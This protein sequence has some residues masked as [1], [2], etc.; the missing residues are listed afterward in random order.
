MAADDAQAIG[1]RYRQQD[2]RLRYRAGRM[3]ARRLISMRA[4]TCSPISC[5][6]GTRF[7]PP[8]AAP[9]PPGPGKY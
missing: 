1:N 4:T 3:A 2:F 9:L 8:R 7:L 5:S 6:T